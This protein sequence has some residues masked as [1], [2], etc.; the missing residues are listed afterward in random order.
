MGRNEEYCGSKEMV[1]TTP[2]V[3]LRTVNTAFQKRGK[4][5]CSAQGIILNLIFEEQLD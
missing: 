4:S 5:A 3:D 2:T 1:T